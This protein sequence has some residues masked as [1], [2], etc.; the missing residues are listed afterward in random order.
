ME[1]VKKCNEVL[2]KIE[3]VIGTAGLFVIFLLITVNIF[4]RYFL[5]SAWGWSGELNGFIYAW[6]AFLSAAYALAD[7]NHVK[8]TILE[9]RLGPRFHHLIRLFTDVVSIIGFA[10]L[11]FPTYAALRT[12]KYTAALRWPK[13]LVYSGLLVGFVLYIVHFVILVIGHVDYFMHGNRSD[14]P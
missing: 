9:A 1:K 13:G 2:K 14:N 3:L 6:I 12:M 5:H 10:W 7:D 8:I 11:C 4:R